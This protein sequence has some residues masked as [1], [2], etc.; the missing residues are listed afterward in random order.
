MRA[1]AEW[2]KALSP[3]QPI[4][5]ERIGGGSHD[6]AGWGA[7]AGTV[8]RYEYR[9][10]CGDGKIIEEHDNVPGFREHDVWIDCDKCRTE[11]RF[12]DG[13][14]VRDWGLE[15]LAAGGTN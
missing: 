7:G 12:V 6:H 3:S 11:W 2:T 14:S 4:R 15:L 9:C 10:P 5:A 13:K 1:I 8:E